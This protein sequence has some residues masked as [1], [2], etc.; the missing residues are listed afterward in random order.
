MYRE[1]SAARAPARAAARS[2][3]ASSASRSHMAGSIPA[4]IP[5]SIA[6]CMP[7]SGG[8]IR[9]AQARP[10]QK[11]APIMP[12]SMPPMSS[13]SAS[14]SRAGLRRSGC[15]QRLHRT[16]GGMANASI[17]HVIHEPA[18]AAAPRASCSGHRGALGSI[19]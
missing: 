7:S 1:T 5:A 17:S 15:R 16:D 8:G 18:S 13:S 19:Q 9:N 4:S 11:W 3:A 12:A 14:A 2:R 6:R 10:N